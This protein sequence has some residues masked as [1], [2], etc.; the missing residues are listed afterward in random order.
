MESGG[1]GNGNAAFQTF[2][3]FKPFQTLT[4]SQR[5]IE[6]MRGFWLLINI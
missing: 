3:S 1:Q 4:E 5:N 2:Q 6:R